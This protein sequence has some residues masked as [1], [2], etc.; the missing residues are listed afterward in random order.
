MA[1]ASGCVLPSA[2]EE[3]WTEAGVKKPAGSVSYLG[4]RRVMEILLIFLFLPSV[5]VIGFVVSLAIWLETGRPIFF[6][7]ERTGKHGRPFRMLKFRSMHVSR[8]PHNT[9]T[10]AADSRLTCVGR[11]VRKH[12][13]DELPQVF[14]VLKGDMSIIGPRPEARFLSRELEEHIP[15]YSRRR[16][17]RPG[18]TGLA[19][20]KQ[21]Y[22]AGI[23]ET[24]LKLEFDLLYIRKVSP[25]LDFRILLGTVSTVLTGS[26]AR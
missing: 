9:L 15:G 6:V 7:Q 8:K 16:C 5:C 11:S 2:G 19:Q 18:L 20:I 10:T 24:G 25:I 14:N 13:L 23:E 17:V 12:R 1:E 21:G 26:G 3:V 22:T 4:L